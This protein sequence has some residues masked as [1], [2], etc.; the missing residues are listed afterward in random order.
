MRIGLWTITSIL[1]SIQGYSH[2]PAM[3]LGSSS[4][5]PLHLLLN[6]DEDKY[7]SGMVL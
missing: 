7:Y 4:V 2:I 3:Y 6:K 1:R 5:F